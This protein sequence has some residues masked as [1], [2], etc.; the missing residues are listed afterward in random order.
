M[1][2]MS[3]AEEKGKEF[4]KNFVLTVNHEGDAYEAFCEG[5]EQA[6]AD[7][8][9]RSIEKEVTLSPAVLSNFG[10]SKFIMDIELAPIEQEK[11]HIYPFNTK[12]LKVIILC[13]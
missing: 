4:I 12:A 13:E 5:Y 3:R 11:L 7:L 2:D 1:S 8:K 9:E 6:I 10:S